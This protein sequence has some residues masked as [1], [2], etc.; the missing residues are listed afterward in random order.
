MPLPRGSVPYL[1]CGVDEILALVRDVPLRADDELVDIG[2]GLGRVAILAHLLSGVRAR[3]IEIQPQLVERSRETCGSL[4][5]TTV[6]FVHANAADIAL[7]GTV[8][9]LYAPCNGPML[10]A[11]M[12]RLAEVARRRP[13]TVCTVGL[14]LPDVRWLSPRTTSSHTLSIYASGM[15]PPTTFDEMTYRD[16]NAN[17]YRF[18][19]AGDGARF[20]YDPITPE[21]SSTGMYSGGDPRSGLL[22]ADQLASLW[23]H[24]TALASNPAIQVADRGKGTGLFVIKA[25]NRERSF[26]IVRGAELQAFDAFVGAL[27]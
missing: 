1:P 15:L 18:H 16:G 7:D 12:N 23:E 20:E 5:L 17:T 21:R 19:A 14:E 3:G 4:G 2:S 9:F 6:A 8:F 25:T 24:V 27:R 26:I 22:G 10:A 13:I 11:V